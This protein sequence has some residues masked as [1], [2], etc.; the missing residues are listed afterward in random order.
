VSD[1]RG[2]SVSCPS[3][4]LAVGATM[5][6]TGSGFAALGQYR[7]VGT[8]NAGST[9]GSVSD[10]DASHYLGVSPTDDG[11]P[12]VDLCHRTGNGS[13]HQISVSVNA[14]P[15]HRAHGDGKIGEPVPGQAGRVFGPGCSVR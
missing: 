7:N 5:T 8:V 6:C 10:S 11:G 1:D 13:Y 2:V 12:K 9:G 15:A 14:E 3:T 4:A